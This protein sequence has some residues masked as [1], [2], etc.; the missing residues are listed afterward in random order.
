LTVMQLVSR[1][2]VGNLHTFPV[3]RALSTVTIINDFV[4]THVLS[5]LAATTN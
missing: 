5:A 3:L 1:L 4:S 2:I